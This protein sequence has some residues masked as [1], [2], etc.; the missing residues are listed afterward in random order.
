MANRLSGNQYIIDTTTSNLTSLITN[1]I[2]AVALFGIDTT[3]R[4]TITYASSTADEIIALA[5]NVNGP[6][7]AGV[8]FGQG[9]YV[10][11]TLRV[12]LLTLGT[13][14]IYLV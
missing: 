4:L 2:I 3:S 12:Q 13:G 1:K 7:L 14:Y 8:S 5:N 10:Q 9:F 6:N 11:D